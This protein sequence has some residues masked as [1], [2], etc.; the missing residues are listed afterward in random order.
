MD[1]CLEGLCMGIGMIIGTLGIA[2][3][4]ILLG[5]LVCYLYLDVSTNREIKKKYE[6]I[7]AKIK[8]IN[9]EREKM[10]KEKG[11]PYEET[12]LR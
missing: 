9:E 1:N 3:I 6:D 11:E 7:E 4:A 12:I 2:I 10:R 8:M 5:T